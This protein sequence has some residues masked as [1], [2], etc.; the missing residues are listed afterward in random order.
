MGRLHERLTDTADE[1]AR[2]ER[3]QD[4]Y[5]AWRTEHGRL[6]ARGQA[7]AQVLQAREDWLLD[8]LVVYPPAYLLV[9]LGPPPANPEGRAAWRRGAQALECYRATYDIDDP[10]RTLADDVRAVATMGVR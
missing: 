10:Y 8:E 2:L 4:A 3:A 7:A 1:I 5:L 6:V 9:E